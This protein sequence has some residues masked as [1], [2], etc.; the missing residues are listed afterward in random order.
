[1]EL[2][3]LAKVKLAE[4]HRW[5]R[6][7][8]GCYRDISF[9]ADWTVSMRHSLDESDWTDWRRH[10]PREVNR[11]INAI[12]G[13]SKERYRV[14]ICLC[15]IDIEKPKRSEILNY[16]GLKS[17]AYAITKNKALEEFAMLYQELREG[18]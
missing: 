8:G 10:A 11:I 17:S 18:L 12:N 13:L 5:L 9:E 14:I 15:Y 3:Q 4:F 6:V 2:K 1:M 7:A 16:I